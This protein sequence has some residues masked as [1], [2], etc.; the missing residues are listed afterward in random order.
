MNAADA[1]NASILTV[2]LHTFITF[3]AFVTYFLAFAAYAALEITLKW[4]ANILNSV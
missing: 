2:W 3:I 1:T 4:K